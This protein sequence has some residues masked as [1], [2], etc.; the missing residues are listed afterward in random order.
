MPVLQHFSVSIFISGSIQILLQWITIYNKALTSKWN[1]QSIY[2]SNQQK[3]KERLTQGLSFILLSF[4]PPR[5][6]PLPEGCIQ[7]LRGSPWA[8][9]TT[10][11]LPVA[12]PGF[13]R[14][15]ARA[16]NGVAA[17]GVSGQTT[18]VQLHHSHR[19]SFDHI[20]SFI[21]LDIWV[22]NLTVWAKK[23]LPKKKRKKVGLPL[24]LITAHIHC[25]IVSIS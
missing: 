25:G 8:W 13:T 10:L 22:N 23:M 3:F 17:A 19:H 21:Q 7:Q 6:L 14:F 20:V 16:P 18:G 5:L 12:P 4:F 11:L 24:V 2:L 1:N 15:T 9:H